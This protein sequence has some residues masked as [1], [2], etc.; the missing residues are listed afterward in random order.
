MKVPLSKDI[1]KAQKAALKVPL[2]LS[3]NRTREKQA[4][5][6]ASASGLPS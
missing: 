6:E 2:K 3:V 5:Q 4:W 1:L